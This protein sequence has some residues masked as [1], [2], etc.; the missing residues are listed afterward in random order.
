[1]AARVNGEAGCS[2]TAPG[3]PKPTSARSSGFRW[4]VPPAEVTSVSA[5][6]REGT[7]E[8]VRLSPT[9]SW[10]GAKIKSQSD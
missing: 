2:P 9:N 7:E 5:E 3:A 6:R 4:K 1:M 10:L 8:E